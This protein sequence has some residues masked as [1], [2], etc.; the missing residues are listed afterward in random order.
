MDRP[1]IEVSGLSTAV[2]ADFLQ[3]QNISTIRPNP[4]SFQALKIDFLS[5]PLMLPRHRLTEFHTSR[6]NSTTAIQNSSVIF[7]LFP[8]V[9]N[10]LSILNFPMCLASP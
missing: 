10:M 7:R 6:K 8:N 2:I 4:A 3:I 5:C 1:W 9:S